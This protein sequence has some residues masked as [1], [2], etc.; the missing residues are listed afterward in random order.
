MS[1]LSLITKDA[2]LI[3]NHVIFCIFVFECKRTPD[4]SIPGFY[5]KNMK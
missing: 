5:L 3:L 4:E 1:E 2:V